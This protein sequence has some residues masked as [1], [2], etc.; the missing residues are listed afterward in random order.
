MNNLKKQSGLSAS[1]WIFLVLIIGGFVSI[2]AKLAPYY[3]DHTTV[4]TILKSMTNEPGLV[5]KRIPELDAMIVRRLKLN[6]IRD[7]DLGN[8]LVMKRGSDRII[9]DLDYEVRI[10][11]V[12]NLE[13]V[14][15]F[16]EHVELRD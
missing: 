11:L 8:R 14:A 16:E 3:F 4:S 7:F 15:S 5:D 13:L 6:N 12:S 1:G 10:P 9:I 2:G